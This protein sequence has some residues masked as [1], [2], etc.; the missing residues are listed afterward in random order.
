MIGAPIPHG[1]A[2]LGKGRETRDIA[3]KKAGFGSHFGYESAKR[4][5]D[6]GIPELVGLRGYP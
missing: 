1:S 5:V 3:A 6:K 4:V 2:E